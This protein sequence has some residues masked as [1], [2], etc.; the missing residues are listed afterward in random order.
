MYSGNLNYSKERD[1][2]IKKIKEGGLDKS[3]RPGF[4]QPRIVPTTFSNGIPQIRAPIEQHSKNKPE[5]AE[6]KAQTASPVKSGLPALA[7]NLT[8]IDTDDLIIIALIAFIVSQNG[9]VD[10]ILVC[11][12]L[13]VLLF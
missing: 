10:I 7:S 12:L 13:Y 5:P 6:R 3:F 4:S 9:E 2:Y 1:E 11:V 8:N